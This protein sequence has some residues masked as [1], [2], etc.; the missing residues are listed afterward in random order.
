MTSEKALHEVI[1]K[2]GRSFLDTQL[3]LIPVTHTLHIDDAVIVAGR[4]QNHHQDTVAADLSLQHHAVARGTGVSGLLHTDIPGTLT[5]QTVRR[6]NLNQTAAGGVLQ[7]LRGGILADLRITI[8]LSRDTRNFTCRRAV[9]G[10]QPCRLFKVRVLQSQF[11]RGFIHLLNES[12]NPAR[13]RAGQQMNSAVVRT[14]ETDVKQVVPRESHSD[15]ETRERGGRQMIILALNREGL[16]HRQIRTHDDQSGHQLRE[17]RD[18]KLRIGVLFEKNPAVILIEHEGA[19]RREIQVGRRRGLTKLLS[20]FLIFGN[21][22]RGGLMR[23]RG[24]HNPGWR[25]LPVNTPRTGDAASRCFGLGCHFLLGS[26]F[27][28]LFTLRLRY[29]MR[30]RIF[31]GCFCGSHALSCQDKTGHRHAKNDFFQGKG[32]RSLCFRIQTT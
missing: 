28:Y 2:L 16:I 24:F 15:T 27:L 17:R 31:G 21:D 32:H 6:T 20:E 22:Y 12:R 13:I 14:G 9:I 1:G 7:L 5:D 23:D 3:A 10:G 8:G 29:C 19:G 18:R 25:K 11:T 26:R 4:I 30:H